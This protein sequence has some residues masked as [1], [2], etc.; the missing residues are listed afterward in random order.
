MRNRACFPPGAEF[1]H[2]PL[3]GIKSC[4]VLCRCNTCRPAVV[5]MLGSLRRAASSWR[6]RPS[7]LRVSRG[8]AR[9]DA[10]Y[11]GWR[12][13]HI[14]GEPTG[15]ALALKMRP[16]TRPSASTSKSSSFHS[17]GGRLAE[18]RLRSSAII[19]LV[20]QPLFPLPANG[21]QRLLAQYIGIAFACLAISMIFAVL[22][23]A[24]HESWPKT[25]HVNC[26]R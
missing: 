1:G 5:A 14:K 9:W 19:R 8:A 17:P 6:T 18:A 20:H 23:N 15:A 24:T 10:A 22:T 3:M 13:L 26:I 21:R 25:H 11:T 7:Q 12:S 4:A 16:T 2:A